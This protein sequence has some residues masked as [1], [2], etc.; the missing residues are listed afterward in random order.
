MKV[1]IRD[2][3]VIIDGYVNV[4]ERDSKVLMDRQGKFI[5]KMKAGVFQRAIDTAKAEHSEI[6]VLLNHNYNRQ[7]TSTADKSTD[8]H[9]DAVGLRCHCEVR[10][11]E[12]MEKAR[13]HK[14]VGWSFG[15]IALK[16]DRDNAPDITHR[17]VRDI[18]LK[19]VSILD[20]TKIPAYDG[21]LIES[22]SEGD[23]SESFIEVRTLDEVDYVE[24]VEN[25]EPLPEEDDRWK[26]ENRYL[27]IRADI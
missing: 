25:K 22:R 7:L 5:E 20:D 17:E 24:H 16:Q 2:D 13:N 15:F 12:V 1:E 4:V 11:A 9:E 10:D 27:A 21:T 23:E 18:I 14:L 3:V 26:F 6:K 8:L 19:E